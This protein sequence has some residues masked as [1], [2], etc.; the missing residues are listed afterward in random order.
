M[1]GEFEYD[2]DIIAEGWFRKHPFTPKML[3]G[4]DFPIH[5]S[6]NGHGNQPMIDLRNDTMGYGNDF[7][8]PDNEGFVNGED[9]R[10]QHEAMFCPCPVSAFT[11]RIVHTVEC[12][13]KQGYNEEFAL[14]RVRLR[15][16][17][18]MLPEVLTPWGP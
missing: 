17:Q 18:E 14:E 6:V 9:L 12:L 11:L 7:F 8:P 13:V 5:V 3:D 15:K 16:S 4:T 10:L 2:P 1:S